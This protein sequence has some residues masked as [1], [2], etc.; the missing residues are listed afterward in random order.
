M[1]LSEEKKLLVKTFGSFSIRIGEKELTEEE[2]NSGKIIHLLSYML[3][4]HKR[5][6]TTSEISEILWEDE[7]N[8][9][10][11][12]A[13]KNLIYRMRNIL[14]EKFGDASM[15]SGGRGVYGISQDWEIETDFEQMEEAVKKAKSSKTI[16]ESIEQYKKAIEIYQGEFLKRSSGERWVVP[17]A[18]YYHS[19]YL[20]SVKDVIKLLKIRSNYADVEKICMEAIQKENMDEEIYILLL[21]ALVRQNKKEL[22]WKYYQETNQKF[23]KDLGIHASDEMNDLYNELKR[24]LKHQENDVHKIFRDLQEAMVPKNVFACEY[25]VF[26]EIFR[27]EFR[28]CLRRSAAVQMIVVTMSSTLTGAYAKTDF[29]D[30]KLKEGMEVFKNILQE[31][32]RM[33]DVITRFS[34]VQWLVLLPGCTPTSAERVMKRL[35]AK[36]EKLP[37]GA[38]TELEYWVGDTQALVEQELEREELEARGLQAN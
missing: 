36:Y 16:W 1:M 22:A 32:L 30:R 38:Y 20:D 11:Q 27:L 10:S 9:N 35:K 37:L 5:V 26:R 6:L 7:E 2:M 24:G 18:A 29:A 21:Q 25:H 3:Y 15:I 17:L 4:H 34:A 19:V 33:G 13:L 31:D 28:R 12:S 14:K 8:V 23:Y